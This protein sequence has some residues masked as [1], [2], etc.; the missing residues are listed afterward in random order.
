MF[1]MHCLSK[2]KWD[3]QSASSG[4]MFV[5]KQRY[6]LGPMDSG[7]SFLLLYDHAN[8]LYLDRFLDSLIFLLNSFHVVL[9]H[10]FTYI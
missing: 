7:V 1:R 8:T 10:V 9:V 2:S 4:D 6:T 3:M 5:G